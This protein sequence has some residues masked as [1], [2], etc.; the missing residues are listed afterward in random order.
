MKLF[1]YL[2]LILFLNINSNYLSEQLR[3][4]L[5]YIVGNS[6]C[7]DSTLKSNNG[8]SSSSNKDQNKILYLT[9]KEEFLDAKITGLKIGISPL[10][11]NLAFEKSFTGLLKN[12]FGYRA[13]IPC[14]LGGCTFNHHASS[15]L[16]TD[17][18][19][20]ILEYG[21]YYGQ[22]EN[23]EEKIY[24]YYDNEGGVRFSHITY[25][26]YKQLV[27][28]NGK[29]NSDDKIINLEI[30]NEMKL[31][32]LI[33]K[34]STKMNLKADDYN[35]ADNNC[36]DLVAYII[37]FLKAKRGFY[38]ELKTSH[39]ISKLIIPPKI[40]EKLEENENENIIAYEK[41]PIIGFFVDMG[42]IIWSKI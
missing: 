14:Y 28:N 21:G 13:L 6:G 2:N 22:D 29:Y 37:F 25:N 17:K 7:Q 30:E 41:I 35:L 12:G 24:Y 31:K 3:K 15:L 34:I 39:N 16:I 23:Y 33:E 1:I 40:L 20:I 19:Y 8:I 11:F 18:G 4:G 27:T 38:D 9:K 10:G 26:K 36:H 5:G 32:T 42:N